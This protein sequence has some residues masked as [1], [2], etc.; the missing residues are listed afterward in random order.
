MNPLPSQ[1]VIDV[2]WSLLWEKRNIEGFEDTGLVL[3]Q[4][5]QRRGTILG[6]FYLSK[7][8]NI[9]YLFTGKVRVKLTFVIR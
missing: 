9:G 4:F 6:K 8:R 5:L 7:K 1:Q 2:A 3:N